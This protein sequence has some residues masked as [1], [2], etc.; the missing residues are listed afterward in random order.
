[1]WGSRLHG[2]L[3]DGT[4]ANTFAASPVQ[5]VGWTG[6]TI[7]A[8]STNALGLKSDGTLCSWGNNF[9]GELGLGDTTDRAQPTPLPNLSGILAFAGGTEFGVALLPDHTCVAWGL[10]DHG[11]MAT[12]FTGS[13]ALAVPVTR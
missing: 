13:T 4:I 12:P 3:G 10:N 7:A 1:S 2:Q 9:Y 6:G 5:V 8:G 11:Q